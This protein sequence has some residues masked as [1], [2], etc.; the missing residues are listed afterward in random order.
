MTKEETSAALAQ[1]LVELKKINARLEVVINNEI[2]VAGPDK[3]V[4]LSSML[5]R[6][7]T[8]AY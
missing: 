1:I 6:C 8:L 7:E 3:P 2:T 5:K 4:D